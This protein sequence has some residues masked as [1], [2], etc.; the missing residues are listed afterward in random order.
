M[1]A[2]ESTSQAHV[3]ADREKGI[4]TGYIDIAASPDRIFR[5]MSTS[6]MAQWWGQ[7]GVYRTHDYKI[8]LK[9]GGKWSCIATGAKGDTSTVGGE[10]ITVDPPR[11]LEYTWEPS[12][13]APNVSRVRIE[14]EPRG[15]GSRVN[16]VHTGFEGR[17]QMMNNHTDGWTRVFGWLNAYLTQ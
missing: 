9:P 5:A 8:D 10:Y 11:V 17:E 15:A 2:V 7:D 14:I 3:S 13:D 6:E 16:I 4:I 12:W 1:T